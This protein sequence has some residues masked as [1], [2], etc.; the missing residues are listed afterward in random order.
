[1]YV[2]DPVLDDSPTALSLDGLLL[3]W[4]EFDRLAAII[5]K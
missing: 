5:S 1:V 2:F 4:E 3:A